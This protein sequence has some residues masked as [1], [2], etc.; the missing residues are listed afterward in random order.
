MRRIGKEISRRNS[1]ESRFFKF[2]VRM[3]YIC[4]GVVIGG[5]TNSIKEIW[6]FLTVFSLCFVF[7]GVSVLTGYI[8]SFKTD[9]IKESMG[10]EK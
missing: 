7:S 9:D 5:L 3:F 4:I 10:R 8:Y 1:I 6:V 2:G